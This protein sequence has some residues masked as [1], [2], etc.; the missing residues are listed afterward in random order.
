[1]AKIQ[2]QY[3]QPGVYNATLPTLTDGQSGGMQL[4]ERGRVI[5]SSTI[6]T[7]NLEINVDGIS[8]SG[9]EATTMQSSA[10]AVGNGT[11]MDV[12]GMETLLLY[13]SGITTATITVE[14]DLPTTN[15]TALVVK[16]VTT[17]QL[18]STI[19]ANGLYAVHIPGL[20]TVRARISSYTSGTIIVT[21][22]AT[23]AANH[24]DVQNVQL[25]DTLS[26]VNDGV[27]AYPYGHSYVNITTNTTT[28]VKTGAGVLR[29]ITV[30][31]PAL[32]T[33]A[34]LTVTIYDNTAASG[35][36]LGTFTVP[37]GLTTALPF[38]LTYE[39]AFTTGLTIVTA[40]P[41]VTGDLTV[42]YR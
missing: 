15:F 41:T 26:A 17:G 20:L 2:A 37:F 30:N 10:V 3:G 8:Y 22:T 38:R 9:I 42:E 12:S 28:T 14:G 23:A 7:D 34:N 24:G 33:V 39:S 27:T 35:T 18:S 36:K 13:V 21:G 4:D 5:T 6:N 31:N 32:L 11:A 16:N 40:G 1:M 19:T 29:G 25:R